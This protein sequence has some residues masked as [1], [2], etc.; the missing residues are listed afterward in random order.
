MLIIALFLAA[1]AALTGIA[2]TESGSTPNRNNTT[3]VSAGDQM[4]YVKIYG[5]TLDEAAGDIHMKLWKAKLTSLEGALANGQ[6]Y[7]TSAKGVAIDDGTN[8]IWDIVQN[9]TAAAL[10]AS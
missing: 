10:P 5:K 8:G 6:Y 1:Y 3:T 2:V 4:P 9:E 7:V